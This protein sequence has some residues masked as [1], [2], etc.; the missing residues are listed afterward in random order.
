[1]NAGWPDYQHIKNGICAL[2]QDT[3]EM[4]YASLWESINGKGSWE[5]NPWVW[6][7]AFRRIE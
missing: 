4:S 7:I 3:A 1:M 6:V 5:K 2:T